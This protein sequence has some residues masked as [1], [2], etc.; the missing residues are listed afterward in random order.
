MS[1]LRRTEP[2]LEAMALSAIVEELMSEASQ[3]TLVYSND[4]SA[5]C[6]LGSYVVQCLSINGKQRTLP[7]F[8]IFTVTKKS[9]RPRNNNPRNFISGNWKQV[10]QRRNPEQNLLRDDR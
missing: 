10:Q 6:G 1:S 9:E 8:G 2:Y 7:T 3:G 5:R 4:G